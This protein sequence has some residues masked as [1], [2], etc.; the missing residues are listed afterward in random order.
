VPVAL[1]RTLRQ[2][3]LVLT[4]FEHGFPAFDILFLL[5]AAFLDGIIRDLSESIT[6]VL[7]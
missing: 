6:R 2:D 1:L 5:L 7:R 4:M 3:R